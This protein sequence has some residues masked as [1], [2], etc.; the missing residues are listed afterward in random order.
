MT[1]RIGQQ[2]TSIVSPLV[3][4]YL[5]EAETGSYPYAVYTYDVEPLETKDGVHHITAGVSL[6]VVSNDFD[7]AHEIARSISDAV[8]SDMRGDGFFS[9]L[10]S[11]ASDCVDG[12]WLI[13]QEY[14]IKQYNS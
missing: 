11:T 8:E 9:A 5:N 14:T 12:V 6:T 3:P 2:L 7:E 13:T 10:R 4:F 1:E